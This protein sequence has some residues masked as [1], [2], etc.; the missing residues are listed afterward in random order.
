ME[1]WRTERALEPLENHEVTLRTAAE[2]AGIGYV[3]LLNLAAEEGVDVG[4]TGDDL[5]PQVYT[6]V[7]RK[8]RELDE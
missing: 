7:Q 5:H 2:Q 4:Y 1:E 8:L 6:K 3:E